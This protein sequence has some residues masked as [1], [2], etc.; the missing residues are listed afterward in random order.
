M[1]VTQKQIAERIGVSPGLV[2]FALNG[3][4]RVGDKTR[5]RILKVARELGYYEH[6]NRAARA[7]GARRHGRRL[8]QGALA[9][10]FS[11]LDE[12]A[13]TDYVGIPF[14]LPLLAGV[15]REASAR[16]VDV[17]VCSIHAAPPRAVAERRVD[18]I[19]GLRPGGWVQS[20]SIGLPTI[21]MMREGGS[22]SIDID[23]RSGIRQAVRHLVELGHR[24][25]A[26]LGFMPDGSGNR[27]RLEGYYEG[28]CEC[29]LP[30]VDDLIEATLLNFPDAANGIDRLL[31]RRPDFTA[32]VCYNDTMAMD[33][34]HRLMQ[35]G[36]RVPDD[37]SVTGF[38]DVS[39]QHHFVPA[40]T[41]VSYDRAGMGARAVQL[42]Y[43]IIDA[44]PGQPA[45]TR[46][47]FPAELVARDSTRRK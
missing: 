6:S 23:D 14:F 13:G 40:L 7:L 47:T 21:S 17:I 29:G 20:D 15:E 34:V 27:T 4:G 19:I 24:T 22:G 16:G 44:A 46:T 8:K 41:S 2:A 38:D 43:D 33:A 42:L 26:Y 39:L 9:V 28:L 37:V 45:A 35:W 11:A 5:R 3:N 1:S 10:T 25:I 30:V 32:L 36:R 31:E 12:S 18:G